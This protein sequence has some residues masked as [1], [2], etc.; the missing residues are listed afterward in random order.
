MDNSELLF[1]VLLLCD[2]NGEYIDFS[3]DD[4]VSALEEANDEDVRFFNPTDEEKAKF[5]R[6]YD[7]L[8]ME[9]QS[10]HD[11][12]VAPVL[13]YNQKKIENWINV[14]MEQLQVQLGDARKE[15][16]DLILAEL[17]ATDSLEKKDIRKKTEEAKKRMDKFQKELSKRRQIIHDEAQVEIEKFKQSQA[18]NPILRINIVLKF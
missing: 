15:V 7:R 1:P 5:A 4:I 3:E 14:Q 18:I 9:V 12:T 8:T 2:E 16:E 11:K 13:A 17:M 10:Q 6:I